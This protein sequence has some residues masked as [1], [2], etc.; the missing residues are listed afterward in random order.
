VSLSNSVPPVESC[1]HNVS[2]RTGTNITAAA[3]DVT[4][5]M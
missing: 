1:E 5:N 3:L 4:L 2:E